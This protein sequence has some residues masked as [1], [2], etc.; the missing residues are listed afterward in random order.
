MTPLDTSLFG[1]A[2]APDTLWLLEIG[3]DE[4][5]LED[6]RR[7]AADLDHAQTLLIGAAFRAAY[8]SGRISTM[9][10]ETAD[11]YLNDHVRLQLHPKEDPQ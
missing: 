6:L 1:P 4:M 7:L 2:V 10:P 11:D 5:P 9:P 3:L 8:A